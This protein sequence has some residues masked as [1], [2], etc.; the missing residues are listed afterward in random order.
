MLGIQSMKTGPGTKGQQ[1]QD[2][3]AEGL[4]GLKN[5]KTEQVEKGDICSR[6]T[7]ARPAHSLMYLFKGTASNSM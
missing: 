1:W 3:D 5:K 6:H 2:L 4:N 7:Q